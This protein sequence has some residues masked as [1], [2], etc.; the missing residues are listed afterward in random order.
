VDVKKDS[1][2][3]KTRVSQAEINLTVS[4]DLSANDY[5]VLYL[6][7]QFKDNKEALVQAAR[8]LSPKEVAEIL[9]AYE[10]ILEN[11]ESSSAIAS[12]SS[13]EDSQ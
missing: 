1:D 11:S 7:P 13:Y 10:K 8:H 3:S 12:P 4:R 2:S 6:L 9:E 5:F